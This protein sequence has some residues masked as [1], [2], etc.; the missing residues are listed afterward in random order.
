MVVFGLARLGLTWVWCL[1]SAVFGVWCQTPKGACAVGVWCLVTVA[2]GRVRCWCLVSGV[3][4]VF[5]VWCLVCRRCLVSGVLCGDGVWC[6]VSGGVI[7]LMK[8]PFLVVLSHA[9]FGSVVL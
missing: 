9:K 3:L 4:A 7:P 2:E 1:V 6:L 8:P 5:G